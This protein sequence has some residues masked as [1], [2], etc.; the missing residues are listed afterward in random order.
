VKASK[1]ESRAV[2]L[3][4]ADRAAPAAVVFGCA[5]TALL[6][7]ESDLF[8]AADPLG[9][10]LFAR[11][12]DTPDQVR[13]LTSELRAAVGRDDAIVMIDQEGGRVRRLRPP[14]W[15]DYPAMQQ[16][17]ARAGNNPGGAAE[18]VML[19][20]RLIAEDLS[21]LGI[22]VDCAPVLDL[23]APGGHEI[24]G[25]RAFSDDPETIARL[26]QA[27]CDGLTAGGVMPVIKHIPGHGRATADSHLE[28]P[29]VET[30]R[31]VLEA[32]DFA[33]F[34]ALRHAPAAMTAHI[35]YDDLDAGNPGSSSSTVVS[36]I[37]RD[38]IGF[39]G[40]LF[41]D[42]VCMKAL[43][44]PLAARVS[45]VLGAGCDVALH[46]DGNFDDMVVISEAC[47]RMRPE[48][49]VRLNAARPPAGD[50]QSIDRDIAKRRISAFLG[51]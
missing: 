12:I 45:S 33:P 16:F 30:K 29:H 17:G 40:L 48:S 1:A 9:F 51:G 23:P 47:P 27:C 24:I 49:M 42:D 2:S 38:Y 13:R 7:E 10:I 44:G 14:H 35:V 26:G 20:Y 36:G 22:D 31:A 21:A 15:D 19:T 34:R 50:S 25:D 37:I 41:S 32:T 18:C 3:S 39:D 11:N 46:C 5:G 28:L 4:D 43:H 6:A 8:R